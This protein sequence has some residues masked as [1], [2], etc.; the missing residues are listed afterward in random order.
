VK[1]KMLKSGAVLEVSESFGLRLME[2]GR[3]TALKSA[4]GPGSKKAA[5]REKGDM[6]HDAGRGQPLKGVD[7]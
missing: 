5:R 1:V 4:P 6:G 7:G 2:Q 3:A